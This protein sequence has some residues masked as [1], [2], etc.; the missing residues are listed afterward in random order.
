MKVESSFRSIGT[1]VYACRCLCDLYITTSER[2]A[3]LEDWILFQH[4]LPVWVLNCGTNPKRQS[5][6]SLII[7]EYGSG[8][9]IWQNTINGHSDVKQVRESHVTFR[10]SDKV[11]FAVLCFND[12]TASKEFFAHYVSIRN[13]HRYKHLFSNGHNGSS[14]CG[15]ILNNKTKSQRH[16]NKSSISN[17]CQFQHITRLQVKDYVRLS[18]LNQCLMPHHTDSNQLL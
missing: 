13:D 8:F 18:L 6:L 3:K 15:L 9:P 12:L 10:L 4:G 5:C 17:P 7:A 2:L 11:T 14:S 16:I 1:N